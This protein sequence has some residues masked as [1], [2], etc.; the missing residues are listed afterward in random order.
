MPGSRCTAWSPAPRQGTTT[1]ATGASAGQ[2]RLSGGSTRLSPPSRPLYSGL[3]SLGTCE[4][5]Q[6]L[7]KQQPESIRRWPLLLS[8]SST[9]ATAT[10]PTTARPASPICLA[11]NTGTSLSWA[12]RTTCC[13]ASRTACRW[14]ARRRSPRRRRPASTAKTRRSSSVRCR[15]WVGRAGGTG[16]RRGSVPRCSSSPPRWSRTRRPPFSAWT[17][18]SSG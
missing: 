16:S 14:T 11:G 5:A 10:R 8:L 7:P 4:S 6:G 3:Y 13:E 17:W 2:A 9:C 15:W 1:A 18:P 12:A